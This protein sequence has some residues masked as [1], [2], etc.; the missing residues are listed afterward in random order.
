MTVHVYDLLYISPHTII[1]LVRLTL[2]DFQL[3]GTSS[4][5]FR[6]I[7]GGLYADGANSML[8]FHVPACVPVYVSMYMYTS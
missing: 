1:V 5:A 4:P 8:I 2:C 7:D 3:P 6:G